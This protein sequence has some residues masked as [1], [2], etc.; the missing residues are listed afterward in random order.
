MSLSSRPSLVVSG[1]QKE[2]CTSQLCDA[3]MWPP[4]CIPISR[5]DTEQGTS[6][7]NSGPS[8][9]FQFVIDKRLS[10]EKVKGD[11][12]LNEG[13]R[14]EERVERKGVIWA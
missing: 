10:A 12:N 6:N 2:L 4:L 9:P 13:A 14:K 3:A 8:L 7:V 1:Q 5:A 11:G